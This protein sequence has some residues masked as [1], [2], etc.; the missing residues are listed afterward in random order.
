VAQ[1][2]VLGVLSATDVLTFEAATPGV[3]TEDDTRA[4]EPAVGADEP[5][6]DETNPVSSYFT[7][8]W[9]NA[10]ADVLERMR[11]TSSPEW[12]VLEEH[13]VSEAMSNGVRAVQADASLAEAA[14][15]ML[16]HRIH[17]ALVLDGS[18]LVGVVAAIDFLRAIAGRAHRR[19]RK[20]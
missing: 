5:R 16:D 15:Y 2:S 9:D 11:S 8:I 1:G 13:V 12:D 6:K 7:D 4:R 20:A 14:S 18:R 17:R 19:P 10:G 3:P